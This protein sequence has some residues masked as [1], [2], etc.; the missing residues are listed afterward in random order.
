MRNRL[1]KTQSR[2][3]NYLVASIVLTI[4]SERQKQ[5]LLIATHQENITINHNN[6]PSKIHHYQSDIKNEI[7]EQKD[8]PTTK[9]NVG[10]GVAKRKDSRSQNRRTLRLQKHPGAIWRICHNH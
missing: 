10:D 5:L 2:K 8:N 3:S 4:D 9:H 7:T 6:T 1:E